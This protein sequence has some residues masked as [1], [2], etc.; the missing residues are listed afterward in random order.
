MNDVLLASFGAEVRDAALRAGKS[1]APVLICGETGC[2]KT[3]LARLIHQSGFRAG[4]PFMRADCASIPESL[5][6]R[7][8][9][10]HTRGS[11]TDAKDSRPGLFEAA[12]G[13]TLFLDEIG[14]LPLSGQPKLLSV[15]DD[16]L[17]RRIGSTKSSHMDVRIIA[18][19][20]R[21]LAEMVAGRQ[22]RS[23]LYYRLAF[24]QIHVPPLRQRPHLILELA[25]DILRKLVAERPVEAQVVPELHPQ[26]ILRLQAHMWPGNIRELEQA[27]T[28]AVTFFPSRVIRREHLPPEVGNG[29]QRAL[30]DRCDHPA[31][32]RYTAPDDRETERRAVVRALEVYE[33]NRTRAAKAL[34]MS[35][36]TLW[37]KLQQFGI[38]LGGRATRTAEQSASLEKLTHLD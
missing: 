22:F 28:F 33:G 32:L 20:N 24:L 7:E 35:R 18:A 21:N 23:D 5:F 16:G 37:V 17:V 30:T 27:L 31:V 15:L 4:K 34:G 11:F 19:T 14:E 8:M 26:T 29:A 2:G 3:V 9:F 13:G 1:N 36:A 12:D 10:G 38:D 25:A 6:E